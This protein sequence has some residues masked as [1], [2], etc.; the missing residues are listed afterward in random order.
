MRLEHRR[1]H[2]HWQDE[3]QSRTRRGLRVHCSVPHTRASHRSGVELRAVAASTDEGRIHGEWMGFLRVSAARRA[4]LAR[5]VRRVLEHDPR[6]GMPDLFQRASSWQGRRSK[7]IYSTG[8]W[9]D[10]DSL[11][12]LVLG[13][14]F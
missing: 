14:S 10:I 11:E 5:A 4:D 12:D 8:N 6:A 2:A 9:L 13:G 3:R 1:R 7:A